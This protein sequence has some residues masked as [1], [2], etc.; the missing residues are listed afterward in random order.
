MLPALSFLVFL[1][2]LALL[3]GLYLLGTTVVRSVRRRQ[4]TARIDDLTGAPHP[5]GQEAIF[6]AGIS[7]ESVPAHQPIPLARLESFLVSADVAL[8]PERFLLFTLAAGLC[9]ALPILALTR[10][11]IAAL[12]VLAGVLFAPFPILAARRRKKNQTLAQQLP[13]ALDM[14]VRALRVGQSVEAALAEV[15][16]SCPPPLGLEIRLVHEEMLLGLPFIEALRNFEARFARLSDVKLMVTA[17]VIQHETGGN[18][19]QIL[20]NLASLIRKRGVLRRQIRALTAESRSS[21]LVLGVLPL[22][23][24]LFFWLVR[25]DYIQVLF[26]D[27]TGRKLLLTAVLLELLGFL[28]MRLLTRSNA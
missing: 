10:S 18:L 1:L 5:T 3:G 26:V 25:P 17:F 11:P 24:G 9:T 4:L 21:S 15:A 22:V 13:E 2:V 27:P 14:I 8:P 16:R 20:D 6:P 12:A 19:T 28:S 23:I 7:P